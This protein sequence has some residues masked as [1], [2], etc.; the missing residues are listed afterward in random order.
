MDRE[1]SINAAN[2]ACLS[3]R[4]HNTAQQIYFL[5][6]V[7]TPRLHAFG[8]RSLELLPSGCN[9][10]A[11]EPLVAAGISECYL[12]DIRDVGQ[13]RTMNKNRTYL[14][15]IA[16]AASMSLLA[17]CSKSED[18]TANKSPAASEAPM[19]T[20]APGYT[21]AP[22]TETSPAPTSSAAPS[23][24]ASLDSAKESVKDAADK[25]GEKAGELKDSAAQ[26]AHEVGSA[27]KEGA[28]KAD[29]KIQESV[30]NG[31]GSTTN[32]P[33]AK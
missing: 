18:N 32:T 30:G 29:Q 31:P 19:S 7:F 13:G 10:H 14:A 6:L 12:N 22:T 26:K 33:A 23:N 11:T 17:A 25:I 1:R 9:Q 16:L 15:V 3:E 27:I 28:A 20:P 8:A 21:P 2:A 5:E 24:G 4:S